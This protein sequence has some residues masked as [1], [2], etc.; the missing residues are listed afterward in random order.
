MA[1]AIIAV[2]SQ[3]LNWIEKDPEVK[4]IVYSQFI[5]MLNVL[6]RICQTERW[7]FEKY[8]GD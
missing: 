2:K 6:A 3:I 8:T 1:T 5:P 7:D 4:I